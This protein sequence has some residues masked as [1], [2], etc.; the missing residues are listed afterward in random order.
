MFHISYGLQW[1]QGLRYIA[2]ISTGHQRNGMDN[3][4]GF[5]S[6]YFLPISWRVP[7]ICTFEMV[8]LLQ[9]SK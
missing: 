5:L 9:T 1:R 3:I 2:E 8:F 6:L 4:T 7:E